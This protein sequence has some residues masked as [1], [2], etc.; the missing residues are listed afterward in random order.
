[1]IEITADINT[2]TNDA[3]FQET[4]KVEAK[5]R[6]NSKIIAPMR[7][8]I[9]IFLLLGIVYKSPPLTLSLFC[10]TNPS[11]MV[12]DLPSGAINT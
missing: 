5:V 7:K 11:P 12:T 8:P 2:I 6:A 3:D 4:K 9:F 1:M 10:F